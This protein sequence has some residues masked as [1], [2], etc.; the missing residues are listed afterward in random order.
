MVRWAIALV[1]FVGACAADAPDPG[2]A[3]ERLA[4]KNWKTLDGKLAIDLPI[5]LLVQPQNAALLATSSDGGFRFYL[6]HRDATTLPAELGLLKDE[7]VALGWESENEQHYENAVEVTFA[8]GKKPNRNWRT[9]WLVEGQDLVVVCEGIAR[10]AHRMRL[11]AALRRT[12]QGM[13]K[14]TP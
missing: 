13:R 3:I 2:A 4:T 11:G 12:C 6:T 5:D 8:R 1:S 7:L 14:G 10:E 9:T